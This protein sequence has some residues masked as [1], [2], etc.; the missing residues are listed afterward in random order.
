M[1][2]KITSGE[3][4]SYIGKG[5]SLKGTLSY[6]GSLHMDGDFEGEIFTEDE[7]VIGETGVLKADI[8]V[9]TIIN[10]GTF[11]GNITAKK[12]I[13]L[14]RQSSLN[15]NIN[16]PSLYME[17]GAEFQGNCSMPVEEREASYAQN[18]EE[19]ECPL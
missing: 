1:K 11:S 8:Q 18:L 3:Q 7:L 2:M 16:S 15:G 13:I 9:G 6:K 10:R 14:Y 12:I 19:A 4:K 17:E 5:V